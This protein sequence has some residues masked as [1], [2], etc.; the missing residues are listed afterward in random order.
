MDFEL[1]ESAAKGKANSRQ[2]I[3]LCCMNE[4]YFGPHLERIGAKPLVTTQQLMYPGGFLLKSALDGWPKGESAKDVLGR[5]A[6][7]YASNQKLSLKSGRGVFTT[8]P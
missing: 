2:A 4:R 5:V 6:S 3:V 1:P 8:R 7:S